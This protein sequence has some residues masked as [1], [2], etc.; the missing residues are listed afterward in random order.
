MKRCH[1][2]FLTLS[3]TLLAACTSPQRPT[4]AVL[5]TDRHLQAGSRLYQAGQLTE[6]KAAFQRAINAAEMIDDSQRLTDALL[7]TGASELLLGDF[8]A[9]DQSYRRAQREARAEGL[10]IAA[11][12]AS[13]ALAETTRRRGEH[14]QA[15]SQFRAI[16]E[17]A[18]LS[19]D[20]RGQIDNG[21]ALCLMASGD[22]EAA[23]RILPAFEQVASGEPSASQAST[24]AN[25]ARLR[26]LQGQP[27]QAETLAD[28][29]LSVDRQLHHPPA[30]AADHAL[31]GEILQ[32][33]GRNEEAQR[34]LETANRIFRQTGQPLVQSR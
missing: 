26:M 12:Q 2:L 23:E 7:A 30:I 17:Q 22:L 3:I 33:A 31:L 19:A 27:A 8:A 20:Q 11:T 1:L 5:A 4:T 6:A 9:A 16:R 29:A 14:G 28:K 15:L 34:H 13:I 18:G 21:M 32:R 24:L 10:S 25:L